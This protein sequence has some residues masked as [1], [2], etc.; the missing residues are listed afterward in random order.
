MSLDG[1]TATVAG[2]SQWITSPAARLEGHRLRDTHDAILVGVGTVLAD[3]PSLTARPPGGGRDPARIVLDTRARTPVTARILTQTSPA[4]T[5]VVTS[6]A[7]H[8]SRVSALRDAGAVVWTVSANAGGVDLAA[9]LARC[10]EES[11]LSVLVE[12][13]SR[14]H[15]SFVRARLI[16]RV[17]AFVAPTVLGGESALAAVGGPGFERLADA[18]AF[19]SWDARPCG[20]DFV[21]EGLVSHA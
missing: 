10:G 1:K 6:A 17:V 8:A 9:T 14:T 15:G 3:D 21:L 18:L 12:G 16:D 7:A 11:L 19:A 13:G 4:P 5:V 20:P 2:E